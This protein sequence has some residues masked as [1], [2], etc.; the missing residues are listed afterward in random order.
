MTGRLMGVLLLL[1]QALFLSV[2]PA[3]ALAR[4]R[5][6]SK[7]PRTSA[8]FDGVEIHPLL[9]HLAVP[10][11]VRQR[12]QDRWGGDLAGRARLDVEVALAVQR[13]VCPEYPVLCRMR[14]VEL[15]EGGMSSGDA[16]HF[17]RAFAGAGVDLIDASA[18]GQASVA[19]WEGRPYYL[20]PRR[21]AQGIAGGRLRPVRR[22]A[23]RGGRRP[24]HPRR[25]DGGAQRRAAGAR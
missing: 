12:R 11:P 15:F 25:E 10:L 5:T 3:R 9:P 17:G 4:R 6:A 22:A 13:A 24:G 14:T 19:E 20:N 23:A 7:G 1:A 16:I 8:G 2:F 18:I 21:R